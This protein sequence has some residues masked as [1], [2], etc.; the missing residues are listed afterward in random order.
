MD[1]D[2]EEN[3]DGVYEKKK[4]SWK[5]KAFGNDETAYYA[6]Q[7]LREEREREQI[8][9]D[10]ENRYKQEQERI[11]NKFPKPGIYER[12][13]KYLSNTKVGKIINNSSLGKYIGSGVTGIVNAPSENLDKARLDYESKKRAKAKFEKEYRDTEEYLAPSRGVVAEE[14]AYQHNVGKQNAKYE[15]EVKD[16]AIA[17]KAKEAYQVERAKTA[18]RLNARD[19]RQEAQQQSRLQAGRIQFR[20][21]KNME[22]KMN[23]PFSREGARALDPSGIFS[24]PPQVIQ[25]SQFRPQQQQQQYSVSHL[26]NMLGYNPTRR[27]N[28]QNNQSPQQQ[29]DPSYMHSLLGFNQQPKN[30]AKQKAKTRRF[31]MF[32]G[33]YYWA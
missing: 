25:K 14:R 7:K 30:P 22:M 12:T 10:R 17:V 23:N 6:Q 18:G 32:T 19:S 29:Y 4:P 33:M 1:I 16:T 24:L 9:K 11:K 27:I 26:N 21:I 28:N 3:A 5:D 31:N 15:R 13:D 2:F 8:N 20:G